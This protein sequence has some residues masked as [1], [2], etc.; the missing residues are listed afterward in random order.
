MQPGSSTSL[1]FWL[2]GVAGV[3]VCQ[4]QCD[5]E[6]NRV[7]HLTKPIVIFI[8]RVKSMASVVRNTLNWITREMTVSTAD[9]SNK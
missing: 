4:P 9:C 3:Q 7:E 5:G 6:K 1:W 2:F 8:V